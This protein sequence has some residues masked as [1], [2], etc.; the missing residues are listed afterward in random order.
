MVA[1][2]H[3]IFL[4]SLRVTEIL[5]Y[6]TRIQ[7]MFITTNNVEYFICNKHALSEN[8]GHH[9]VRERHL[10]SSVIFLLDSN[11]QV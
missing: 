7:N 10:Y 9:D 5:T 4:V 11:F 6:L 1:V 2:D 8:A 3:F